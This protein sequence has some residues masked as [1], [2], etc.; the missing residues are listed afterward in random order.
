[1]LLTLLED[2]LVLNAAVGV[3]CAAAATGVATAVGAAM[4][5][6]KAVPGPAF[7][8]LRYLSLKNLAALEGDNH[9]EVGIR[10]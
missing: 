6:P 10:E 4:T 1:M 7:L 8:Q 3:P 9:E 5:V 2:P